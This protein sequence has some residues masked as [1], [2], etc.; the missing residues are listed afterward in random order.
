M[1]LLRFRVEQSCRDAF[2]RAAGDV[3]STSSETAASVPEATEPPEMLTQGKLMRRLETAG[4]R[5][6]GSAIY[7]GMPRRL[8][9]AAEAKLYRKRVQA[10]T[11]PDNA[12]TARW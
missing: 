10:V 2:I 3:L 4:R 1:S 8:K 7:D 5:L 9:G 11:D 12:P 6:S